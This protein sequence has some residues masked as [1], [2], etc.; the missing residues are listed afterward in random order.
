MNA[1]AVFPEIQMPLQWKKSTEMSLRYYS[2]RNV[3]KINISTDGSLLDC[4]GRTGVYCSQIECQCPSQVQ[5]ETEDGRRRT[6][7][8]VALDSRST[9]RS[10]KE[11]ISRHWL[12]VGVVFQDA[13]PVTNITN[14]S[15]SQ[16]DFFLITNYY[17]GKSLVSWKLKRKCWW[18]LKSKTSDPLLTRF[19]CSTVLS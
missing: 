9:L 3:L 16:S 18:D 2:G 15:I 1:R 14:L 19:Q 12:W 10:V 7:V 13:H 17:A 11:Q 5:H 4:V 6:S 8:H